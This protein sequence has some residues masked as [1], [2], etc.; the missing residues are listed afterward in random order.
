MTAAPTIAPRLKIQPTGVVEMIVL[1][2]VSWELYEL[3][4]RDV[5]GQNVR[6]TYDQGRMV[7]MSPLSM[8]EKIKV[9]AGR[10]IEHATFERDIPI[11]SFG[12][13]TWKRQDLGKGLEPDECYYIQHEPQV[14]GRTDIDL[15]R[16][17]PPD[18][19]VEIDI[20][21]N[22]LDRPSIYAALGVYE[23]WRYDGER[24]GFVRRSAGG[25]YEPIIR[26][27]ALPFMTPQIVERFVTLMLA[28]ENGGLR[29]FRDWLRSP[30]AALDG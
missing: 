3:L 23:L 5:D 16:D 19:A 10:L 2:N 14:H 15:K 29:A 21:H 6:I 1:D 24:F 18:L 30:E 28:D 22:P 12:S 17:P 8:H 27:E 26:S 9:M 4:L 7:L 13:T 25:A 11:S 20:T